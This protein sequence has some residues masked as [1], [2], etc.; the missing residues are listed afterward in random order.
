MAK[1]ILFWYSNEWVK[2]IRFENTKK[3]REAA[4]MYAESQKKEYCAYANEDGLRIEVND[5][6]ISRPDLYQVF[7]VHSTDYIFGYGIDAIVVEA[8]FMQN[9]RI[10]RFYTEEDALEYLKERSSD[11][12]MK[13]NGDRGFIKDEKMWACL[14]M[15][16]RKELCNE[17]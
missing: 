8:N 16:T 1:G 3:A 6:W 13:L 5:R 11:L 2:A 15:F 14:T 12:G 4:L 9:L 10:N 17:K 7:E